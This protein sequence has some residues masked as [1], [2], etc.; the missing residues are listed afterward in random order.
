MNEDASARQE[1]GSAPVP[2]GPASSWVPGRVGPAPIKAV[3]MGAFSLWR[4]GQ[5]PSQVTMPAPAGPASPWSPRPG[6]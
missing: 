6:A 2:A 5:A 4:P 1:F 3:P